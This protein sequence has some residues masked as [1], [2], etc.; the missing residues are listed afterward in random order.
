VRAKIAMFTISDCNRD[1]PLVPHRLLA[2]IV[3][4][5]SSL[6]KIDYRFRCHYYKWKGGFQNKQKKTVVKC[7]TN[8]FEMT[9]PTKIELK[10]KENKGKLI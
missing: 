5:A 7:V 6:C 10:G 9:N 3:V 4:L 8:F 2:R 1:H